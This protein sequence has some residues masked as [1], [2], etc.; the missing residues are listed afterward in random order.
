MSPNDHDFNWVQ[1]QQN[2][3]LA[4]EYRKLRDHVRAC[5]EQC[6]PADD[7]HYKDTSVGFSVILDLGL[8][9]I[10][11]QE[12][13]F[14]LENDSIVID[15]K[16]GGGIYTVKPTLNHDGECRYTIDGKGEYL[17]WQVARKFLASM[18][19]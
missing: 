16:P 12:V 4:V 3:S 19:F 15:K 7:L 11:P 2:C 1:A 18:F 10:P 5:V 13:E 17:R 6:Q 8:P 14:I 9:E